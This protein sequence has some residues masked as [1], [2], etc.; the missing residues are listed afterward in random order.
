MNVLT[1]TDD[2]RAMM[3][4]MMMILL[5]LLSYCSSMSS[6]VRLEGKGREGA[7]IQSI[8]GLSIDRKEDISQEVV[9]IN[10]D[11]TR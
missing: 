10:E 2:V 4:M 11:R 1:I 8:K 6:T 9:K 5:L 7:F 3:M